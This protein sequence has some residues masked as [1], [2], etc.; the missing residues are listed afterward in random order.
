MK[1]FETNKRQIVFMQ[2]PSPGDDKEIS[3]RAVK[4]AGEKLKTDGEKARTKST[5]D[6]KMTG[7]YFQH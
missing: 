1:M 7:R 5:A 2:Y 4:I 6:A 3:Q